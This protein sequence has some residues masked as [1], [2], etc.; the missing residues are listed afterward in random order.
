M[1]SGP[2]NV[3]K[4]TVY[5]M[6]CWQNMKQIHRILF[7]PATLVLILFIFACSKQERIVVELVQV[8]D[9][10]TI[11]VK[12]NGKSETVR[13]LLVD[14]PETSH[15]KL[16]AQP[17]GPEAKQFTKNMLEGA[18]KIELEFDSG[19]K[20]DKY[21]RLLAYVYADGK[22][23][24][25]ELLKHGWARVAYVYPP[26]TRHLDLFRTHEKQS[27]RKEIGIWEFKNYAR[28]DGFHPEVINNNEKGFTNK[29]ASSD[30]RI[31]GNINSKGQKIYHTPSSRSYEQTK[32]E[33]WFCSEQEAINSG[34]RKAQ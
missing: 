10:D 30:C 16:G 9:G 23:V 14:T 18:Q 12:I 19:P 15:P 24:Q 26:N 22:M 2:Y 17:F 31:K 32:P 33:V 6:E 25:E 7:I 34:F 28:D 3:D 1:D 13:F 4:N 21:S 29:K 27:K 11:R 20:R 5:L 8:H